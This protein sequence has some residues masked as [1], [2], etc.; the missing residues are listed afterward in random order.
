MAD[1]FGRCTSG[2]SPV[3]ADNGLHKVSSSSGEMHAGRRMMCTAHAVFSSSSSVE[4]FG[5]GD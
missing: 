4:E 1:Q 5:A 2:K 3:N